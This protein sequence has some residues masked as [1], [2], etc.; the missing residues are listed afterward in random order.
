MSIR[1]F[2]SFWFFENAATD[3]M[4]DDKQSLVVAPCGCTIATLPSRG[5]MF[6]AKIAID[7][8]DLNAQRLVAALWVMFFGSCVV[9]PAS[10][11]YMTK[12]KKN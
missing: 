9:S 3:G 12:T 2:P 5:F 1:V 7:A 11:G 10:K 4:D 8:M 6:I